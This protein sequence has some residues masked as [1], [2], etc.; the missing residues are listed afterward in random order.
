MCRIDG[1][2]QTVALETFEL[3][4]V[5]ADGTNLKQLT[6][7]T[8]GDLSGGLA[9]SPDSKRIVFHRGLAAPQFIDGGLVPSPCPLRPDRN[10][11]Q[12]LPRPVAIRV[13]GFLGG[14]RGRRRMARLLRPS[15]VA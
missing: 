5:R 7:N 11:H 9:W 13:A 8:I 14:A 10:P 12:S 6:T 4:T 1:D 15:R 2:P 3:S